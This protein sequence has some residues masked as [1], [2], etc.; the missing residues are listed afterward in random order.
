MIWFFA[1]VG[2]IGA[3]V[4]LPVAFAFSLVLS[5]ISAI[6]GLVT[7]RF[8]AAA[9]YLSLTVCP[10]LIRTW[11]DRLLASGADGTAVLGAVIL[12][13]V[14]IA[15]C[16]FTVVFLVVASLESKRSK[17]RLLQGPRKAPV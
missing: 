5:A 7:A 10:Y 3:V 13:Y 1:I 16:F 6:A 11:L 15:T 2:V 4:A 9:M 12:C 8:A 14:A 17:K